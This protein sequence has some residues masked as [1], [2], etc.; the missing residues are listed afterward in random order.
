VSATN[1]ASV[2]PGV[3]NAARAVSLTLDW[4]PAGSAALRTPG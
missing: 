3:A 1:S 2:A 4:V